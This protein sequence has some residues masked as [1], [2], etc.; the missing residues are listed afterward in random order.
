GTGSRQ[1]TDGSSKDRGPRFS[2]DGS[3]IAFYSN[4][5]GNYQVWTIK[6]D[7]SELQQVTQDSST[8]GLVFPVWSRDGRFITASAFEAKAFV[9][10]VARPW[11]TQTP[12]LLPPLPR[13][14][15]SFMA[16]A[17]SPSGRWLS[18]WQL[19]ADGTSQGILLYDPESRT[20]RDVTDFGT[21]PAWTAD[22]RHL[23]FSGRHR[24]LVVELQTRKVEEL[25][26]GEDFEEEFAL[27]SDRRL[28]YTVQTQREG[29]VW[30]A[31]L[32]PLGAR[33]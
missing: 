5:T 32:P 24:R 14:G 23:V 18:G 6:P 21:F 1:L 15:H 27:S 33:P 7:G 12:A 17:W 19:G 8:S 3:R 28:M 30:I 10:E 22:E 20:Y 4:R 29:D 26:Q 2:P 25:A 16:W 9:T 13:A 31:T 11:G